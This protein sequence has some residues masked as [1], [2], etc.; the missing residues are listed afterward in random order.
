MTALCRYLGCWVRS[1]PN[2]QRYA[3][4]VVRPVLSRV[5]LIGNRRISMSGVNARYN[6]C[7]ANAEGQNSPAGM[8][9]QLSGHFDRM[10]SIYR[11]HRAA[12][13]PKRCA[14]RAWSVSFMPSRNHFIRCRDRSGTAHRTPPSTVGLDAG[15]HRKLDCTNNIYAYNVYRL[16]AGFS[17]N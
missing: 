8:S 11:H 2:Q 13:S 15:L 1:S 4:S 10:M 17:T 5:N 16:L 3:S 6:C 9:F 12:S 7:I 14:A